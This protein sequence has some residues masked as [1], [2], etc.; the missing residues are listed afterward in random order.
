MPM[1]RVACGGGGGMFQF[2]ICLTAL[3]HNAA[4]CVWT[5]QPRGTQPR[6]R[7]SVV[8][9]LR[10]PPAPSTAFGVLSRLAAR[11]PPAPAPCACASPVPCPLPDSQRQRLW[12]LGM[13]FGVPPSESRLGLAF[14]LPQSRI[15][16]AVWRPCESLWGRGVAWT[17]PGFGYKSIRPLGSRESQIDQFQH[18]IVV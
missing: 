8:G 16:A 6:L 5:P 13:P 3:T 1:P 10:A 12:G 2:L 14:R 17:F 7:C 15:L 18:R 4:W 11:R 9:L